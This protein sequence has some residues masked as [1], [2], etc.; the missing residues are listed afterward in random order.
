MIINIGSND[1]LSDPKFEEKAKNIIRDSMSNKP[2]NTVFEEVK[3][4]TAS[5]PEAEKLLDAMELFVRD[6]TVGEYDRE[7]LL[8]MNNRDIVDRIDRLKGYPFDRYLVHIH[9]AKSEIR[10]SINWKYTMKNLIINFKQEEL[11]G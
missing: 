7:L 9:N 6:V 8:N 4:C 11:H 5:G 10:R 2:L 1:I 3:E